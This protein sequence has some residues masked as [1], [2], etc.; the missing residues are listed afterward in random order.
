MGRAAR[1]AQTQG[2][3]RPVRT[4]R[5]AFPLWFPA[6]FVVMAVVIVGATALN[7]DLGTGVKAAGAA[8]PLV[9][10]GVIWWVITDVRMVLCEGG[11]L[12]GSFAP[13]LSPYAI[14]YR[15]IEPHGV[16]CVSDVGRLPSVT[17]RTYGSSLFHFPQSRRGLV[18]AGPPPAQAR[19]RGVAASQVSGTGAGTLWA[20][21]YRG[22]PEE[23]IS[24][25]QQGML[26]QHV[27]HAEMLP[28]IALPERAVADGVNGVAR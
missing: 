24:L 20:F 26:A 2:L 9:V 22:A 14:P 6:L 8:V 15:Q 16:T 12:M 13:L 4:Y 27:P 21:A 1:I 3:G 11:I 23:L 19:S 5:Q 28:Q 18:L 7:P 17:G 25:L 10:L